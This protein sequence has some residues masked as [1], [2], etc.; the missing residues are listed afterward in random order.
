VCT[1]RAAALDGPTLTRFVE[2]VPDARVHRDL[3]AFAD[4]LLASA[5]VPDSSPGAL[6]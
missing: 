1:G 6:V 4:W 2:L 3:G 5:H